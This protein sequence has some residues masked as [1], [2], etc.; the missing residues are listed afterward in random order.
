MVPDRRTVE[1]VQDLVDDVGAEHDVEDAK[2]SAAGGAGGEIEFVGA[3]EKAGP[4]ARMSEQREGLCVSFVRAWRLWAADDQGSVAGRRGEDAVV[5][6]EVL[7]GGRNLG[8]ETP[9][10]GDWLEE[11]VGLARGLRAA[12]GESHLAGRQEPHLFG[13]EWRAARIPDEPLPCDLGVIGDEHASVDREASHVLARA[14]LE[15]S[16]VARHRFIA[17]KPTGLAASIHDR[18]GRWIVE[19]G[20]IAIDAADA[21]QVANESVV[22]AVGDVTNIC[23]TGCAGRDEAQAGVWGPDIE[24]RGSALVVSAPF[25]HAAPVCLFR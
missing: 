14:R 7:A 22:D 6:H 1:V 9:N 16:G 20:M 25:R 8:R 11:N 4:A 19:D 15:F 23:R 10:E 2:A 12:T 21:Y 5:A 24:A 13:G 18:P 3:L 17:V